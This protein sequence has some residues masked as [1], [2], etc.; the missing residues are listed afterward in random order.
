MACFSPASKN[1]P[2]FEIEANFSGVDR[3][4]NAGSNAPRVTDGKNKRRA[5]NAQELIIL[6]GC[7]TDQIHTDIA[8]A[9]SEGQILPSGSQDRTRFFTDSPRMKSWLTGQQSELLLVY[10]NQSNS[11]ISP[12]TFASGIFLRSLRSY[13]GVIALSFFCSMHNENQKEH[14]KN[15]GASLMLANITSQLLNSCPA[16]DFSFLKKQDT[17]PFKQSD[18]RDG[19]PK[20]LRALCVL[21]AEL[22]GQLPSDQIVFCVI[23]GIEFYEFGNRRVDT[24]TVMELFMDL[25]TGNHEKNIKA[26]FKVLITTPGASLA[27]YEVVGRA[28]IWR[29]P[30]D[31]GRSD[32]HFNSRRRA[33]QV[34]RDFEEMVGLHH[35]NSHPDHEWTRSSDDENSGEGLVSEIESNEDGVSSD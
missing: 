30:M 17:W 11:I 33:A 2:I 3:F 18:L 4:V 22:M 21:F 34:D 8:R 12:L 19:S 10:G 20:Y 16:F 31:V 23:D 24:C 7:D 9:L 32:Q 29:M 13:N 1:V 25:M 6:L 15:V 14:V 5:F 35:E 27:V 26:L 28:N